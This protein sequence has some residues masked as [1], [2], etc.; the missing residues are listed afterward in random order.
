VALNLTPVRVVLL[1][2]LIAACR[3]G[4]NYPEAGEPRFAGD[5]AEAIAAGRDTLRIVTYN[6]EFARQVE[7]AAAVMAEHE[8]LRDADIVALQ[9]MTE[10]ATE[11]IARRLRM[12]Y[13]YYPAI[14]HGR[15]KQNFGN[16]VL[17]RWPIVDDAKVILPHQSQYAGTQR[18]ATAATIRIADVTIR[19]Y[20]THLG[21]PLDIGIGGGRRRDQLRAI[22]DHASS[23]D[24]VI[25]AGDLN[26]SDVGRVAADAGYHWPTRRVPR[27]TSVGRWDH[28]FLKGLRAPDSAAAGTVGTPR[29]ISDHRPV[30][31]RALV[32]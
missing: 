31:A 13:A 32:R 21:T 23:Y 29:G 24:R 4:R 30:W 5:F 12:A 28:V 15:T 9:E 26:D 11:S 3:S 25:I 17:S 19:V 16:A 6:I 20:S 22:I 14:H 27:S 1:S 7:R 18:T 8:Q 2:L 10:A